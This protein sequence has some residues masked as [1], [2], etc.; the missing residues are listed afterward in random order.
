MNHR[1]EIGQVYE[2]TDPRMKGRR[3]RIVWKMY[4]GAYVQAENVATG[5]LTY[6]ATHRLR[7]TSGKRGYRL[8]GAR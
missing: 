4:G 5:R 3:I 1:V 7:P 8:V 2:D 6:I